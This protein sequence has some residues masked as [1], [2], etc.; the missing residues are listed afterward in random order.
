MA[1]DPVKRPDVLDA[2]QKALMNDQELSWVSR[3]GD[4]N[5]DYKRMARTAYDAAM[6]ALFPA[7]DD[8][9]SDAPVSRPDTGK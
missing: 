1:G 9:R 4:L 7:S 8:F 3:S 5:W 6:A 2:I